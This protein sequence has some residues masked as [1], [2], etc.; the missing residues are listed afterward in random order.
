MT[1]QEI[2]DKHPDEEFL[3]ADGFDDCI[4]GVDAI[5]NRIIYDVEK[6]LES[7]M[8]QGMSRGEAIEYLYFNTV[9]A[10]VGELTP[11]WCE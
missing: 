11:I 8:K 5:G 9:E 10:Y 2:F 6:C 3:F 7:L 1:K 4:L